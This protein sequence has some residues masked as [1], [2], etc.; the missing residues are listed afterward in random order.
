[1]SK[2]R[3][4]VVHEFCLGHAEKVLE[5][6]EAAHG[7]PAQSVRELEEWVASSRGKRAIAEAS[8]QYLAES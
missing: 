3:E 4:R 8:T 6:F 1:M 5:V 2:L 7:R